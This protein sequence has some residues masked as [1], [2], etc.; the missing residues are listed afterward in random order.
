MK[1]RKILSLVLALVLI[2][3]ITAC[4]KPAQ[5][6]QTTT[7]S[8]Q[9]AEEATEAPA[10]PTFQK[11]T[12]D[13]AGFEITVPD[14]I[15]SIVSFAPSMT[16]ILVDL[17]VKDKLVAVDKQ[18]PLYAQGLDA[19]P[20]FDMMTPDMEALAALKPDVMFVSGLSSQTSDD[21]FKQLKDLGITVVTIPSS[22]SIE[23]IK[24]DN[25]FM[26]DVL[27][28]PEQGKA[29]NEAFQAR[30]DEIKAIGQTITDKKSVLFEISTLPD[31]YSTGTG[32]FLNEMIE[33]IGATNVLADQTSWMKVTEEEAISR[34]PDVI[35][36]NVN[37]IENPVED[38][39]GRTGWG[40]VTAIKN[41]DVHYIDNGFSSLPNH[42]IVK[43]LAEMAKA[44]Y[45]EQFKD[46]K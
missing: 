42:N 29:L 13:R 4:Q 10:Q 39:L 25:Q 21:P 8:V 36:T 22:A 26:A 35:L 33:L 34:N 30:I 17:G 27:G 16:Q 24:T 45:P 1:N 5:S 37:Y 43:A 14:E 12:K 2:L 40:E 20:Q 32:T 11:P 15:N 3:S 19:L 38:V 31:I 44:V 41:K 28:M 7:E 9:S 6:A 46:L 18:S 23:D